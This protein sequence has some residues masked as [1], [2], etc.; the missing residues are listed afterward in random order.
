MRYLFIIFF[1]FFAA[2]IET[3]V[4]L[5][6]F[7]DMMDFFAVD[8]AKIQ[9]ILTWNFLGLCLSGLFYGP[10]S[11]S[12]G[13]RK[14]LL[15]ALSLFLTGSILTVFAG[16]FSWMLTGRVLQGL[17]SGGCF[18]LG[19]AILFDVFKG[20]EAINAL[21]RMNMIVP[22]LLASA[23]MVGGHLNYVFGFQSNFILIGGIVC[24][25]FFLCLFYFNE[26]LLEP[27]PFH[28]KKVV[29]DFKR[30]SLNISFWQLTG[31]ISLLFAGYLAFLAAIPALFI[32]EMRVNKE[33][34]PFYQASVLAG[35]LLASLSCSFAIAKWGVA[36]VKI[37]GLIFVAGGAVTLSIFGWVTP[38]PKL[39]TLAM[40]PYAFG[41]IWVQTPY[42]SEVM[43][44]MPEI[45]GIAASLLTSARLL[46]T[47][48]VVGLSGLLYDG[49]IIP[50]TF[51]LIA[52]STV[53]GIF[54]FLHEIYISAKSINPSKGST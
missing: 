19:T 35:Y 11:D 7:P 41:F 20:K 36:R 2:C 21:N 22:F 49:T 37:S 28:F 44:L 32:L 16:N 23:P 47:A 5:P 34:F 18:T 30:V 8:E 25:S 26:T 4:Y 43:E 52:I 38:S 1:I 53:V 27:T 39:L 42:V 15:I 17:G 33:L 14:P 6:S 45:K 29:Q 12:F 40:M 31:I 24:F 48:G 51:L 46:I 13:R 3:D 10:L 50:L 9:K 54:M